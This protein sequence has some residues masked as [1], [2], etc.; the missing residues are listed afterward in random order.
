MESKKNEFITLAVIVV[1]AS[2]MM[3]AFGFMFMQLE[4]K[5]KESDPFQQTHYYDT[6]GTVLD[7]ESWAPCAGSG[8]SRYID[9]MDTFR[10]YA[11]DFD[12]KHDGK[13][14]RISSTLLFEYDGSPI[15]AYEVVSKEGGLTTYRYSEEG[16]DYVFTVGDNCKVT[17]MSIDDKER[18]IVATIKERSWLSQRWIVKV[19]RL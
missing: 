8:S 12:L 19:V 9:Y 2:I 3:T 7:D 6:A 1:I 11:F 10:T 13:T 18:R 4:E 15:D 17:R 5:N 14:Y 16:T